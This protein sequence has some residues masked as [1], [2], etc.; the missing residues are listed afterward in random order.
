MYD[1]QGSGVK[2]EWSPVRVLTVSQ[3]SSSTEERTEEQGVLT[4]LQ[5]AT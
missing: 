2:C 5:E 4:T 3:A 1:N